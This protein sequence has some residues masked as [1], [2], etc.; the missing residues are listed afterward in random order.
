L[1][2][3]RLRAGFSIRPGT[4]LLG[5]GLGA[6][7][8]PCPPGLL[9]LYFNETRRIMAKIFTTDQLCQAHAILAQRHVD[10]SEDDLVRKAGELFPEVKDESSDDSGQTFQKPEIESLYKAHQKDAYTKKQEA[11]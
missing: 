6:L 7:E 5:M 1:V 9:F 4:E 2:G 10:F 3:T 11:K 8:P